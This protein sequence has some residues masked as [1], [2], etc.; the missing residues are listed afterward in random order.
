M[1][2]RLPILKSSRQ[3]MFRETNYQCLEYCN[4]Y[5]STI[6]SIVTQ[7]QFH[8]RKKIPMISGCRYKKIYR[9]PSLD[10]Q[11][12][13]VIESY[14]ELQFSSYFRNGTLLCYSSKLL[15]CTFCKIISTC[16]SVFIR[17]P[18]TAPYNMDGKFLIC[19]VKKKKRS[20]KT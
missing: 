15:V 8:N 10:L 16:A 3:P 14:V 19:N 6:L 18:I 11:H 7:L 5:K 12:E 9:P 2:I 4:D 1:K 13:P 17:L 20:K